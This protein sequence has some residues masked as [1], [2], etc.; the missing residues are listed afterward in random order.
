MDEAGQH[1]TG[2]ETASS[3]DTNEAH[4]AHVALLNSLPLY[5]T[6]PTIGSSEH[7]DALSKLFEWCL[8]FSDARLGISTSGIG[9]IVRSIYANLDGDPPENLAGKL[10]SLSETAE[11][12][13]PWE[14]DNDIFVSHLPWLYD[15]LLVQQAETPRDYVW[16]DDPGKYDWWI[17]ATIASLKNYSEQ[18]G[19]EDS[20]RLEYL[21]NRHRCVLFA[22]TN[23]DN[24]LERVDSLLKDVENEN[25]EVYQQLS[26]LCQSIRENVEHSGTIYWSWRLINFHFSR[27]RPIYLPSL[28]LWNDWPTGV[29]WAPPRPSDHKI[30]SPLRSED[31]ADF[32]EDVLLGGFA[33]LFAAARFSCGLGEAAPQ[34]SNYRVRSPIFYFAA[35]V[36]PP[37]LPHRYTE[38]KSAVVESLGEKCL[39]A[40]GPLAR[41]SN[42][43]V[44]EENLVVLR[45]DHTIDDN[46]VP[47]YLLLPIRD[48]P[49]LSREPEQE[50]GSNL[51]SVF[52]HLAHLEFTQGDG[53]EDVYISSMSIS[54][55][56]PSWEKILNEVNNLA[57]SAIDFLPS[58]SQWDH[59]QVYDD[60]RKLHVLQMMRVRSKLRKEKK[61][62]EEGAQRE[63]EKC[64][65]ETKGLVQEMPLTPL[66]A[67]Q[68][69][70][71]NEMLDDPFPY[72]KV[73]Q[74]LTSSTNRM[75]TLDRSIERIDELSTTANTVLE[76]ADQR[77]RALLGSRTSALGLL[78]GFLALIGLSEF[79]PGT[80]LAENSYPGWLSFIPLPILVTVARI[81][82]ILV[83]LAA[84]FILA[85]YFFTWAYE[86]LPFR[87]KPFSS[88]V[89]ELWARTELAG[90]YCAWAR[91]G[92]VIE[93]VTEDVEERANY[94]N[95]IVEN[96]PTFDKVV[97]RDPLEIVQTPANE[98]WNKLEQL[99][100][101]ATRLLHSLWKDIG[102]VRND[103]GN[104]LRRILRLLRPSGSPQ[105]AYWLRC[106][107]NLQYHIDLFALCPEIIPLPRALCIFWYKNEDPLYRSMLPD[108]NFRR[109]LEVAGF[110]EQDIDRLKGWLSIEEN[111]KRI[112]TMSPREFGKLLEKREVKA[113]DSGNR[114]SEKWAGPL[115]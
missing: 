16:V 34:V 2:T 89:Q 9:H 115:E 43:G 112:R 44:W 31:A 65:N 84:L 56:Q 63:L 111:T 105:I 110:K 37:S 1:R 38:D 17:K 101:Q 33:R 66:S 78:V 64:K 104:P 85:Y 98:A 60:F 106:N 7:P 28:A 108:Q 109:S 62:F 75:N 74:H 40:D 18:V 45:R 50:L 70:S 100:R 77:A 102:R 58:L 55:R 36:D 88:K 41:Q 49:S 35:P 68:V 6:G 73:D 72:Q 52:D 92:K 95:M 30:A 19:I 71:L 32:L 86:R 81:L 8:G 21:F 113:D 22:S 57:T 80:Q 27:D 25:E 14:H 107:R 94:L 42:W 15:L 47:C 39:R 3:G 79:I 51:D 76:T 114:T 97:V 5:W 12:D 11:V 46:N 24:L 67:N 54:E 91:W 10:D 26:E 61:G 103:Q 4:I 82:I 83:G 96:Q 53:A 13:T 93:S 23:R 20:T 69:P 90:A 29:A 99:D 87:R 59:D 48:E